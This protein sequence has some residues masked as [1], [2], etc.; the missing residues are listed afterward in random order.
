M[1]I[2]LGNKLLKDIW[3]HSK[4]IRA[5]NNIRYNG[6]R[7]KYFFTY[8]KITT[9]RNENVYKSE[10]KEKKKKIT[11]PWVFSSDALLLF[12]VAIFVS[13][14]FWMKYWM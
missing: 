10:K 13:I 1:N 12:S 7:R 11:S 6:E 2:N 9:E 5:K 14:A 4:R 8:K 3:Y